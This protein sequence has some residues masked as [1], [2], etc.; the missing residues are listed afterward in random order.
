MNPRLGGHPFDMASIRSLRIFVAVVESQSFTA[1]ARKLHLGI[2][3]VSKSIAALEVSLGS[4]L[5]YRNTR[6][7]AVTDAGEQFYRRCRTI[8]T[9]I[10]AACFSDQVPQLNVRGHL[11]IAVSP[12]FGASVLSPMLPHFL[13]QYPQITADVLVSSAFPNLIR[14]Q[15]DVAITLRNQP[16]TK[17]ASLRLARNSLA[18]CASPDYLKQ[19][20]VPQ[21]PEDLEN[22]FALV[23]LLSGVHDAWVIGTG[24]DIKVAQIRSVFAS[25][26]GNVIKRLC[27]EGLGIA[28]LYRFHAYE[29]LEKGTLVELFPGRQPQTHNIHA[30][31]PHKEM[32]EPHTVAFVNFLRETIGDPPYWTR[33]KETKSPHADPHGKTARRKRAST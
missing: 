10:N 25:D 1:A 4:P 2:S 9:E 23:S 30:V 20:G 29:E 6:R 32:T 11:R 17:T 15:I 14:D 19:R 26:D 16:E 12:S 22:H 7:V 18:L 31:F 3:T 24:N 21:T 27:L 28:N 8:M 5:I 33:A 13:R